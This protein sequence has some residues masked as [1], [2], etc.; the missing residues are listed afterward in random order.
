MYTKNNFKTTIIVIFVGIFSTGLSAFL[1][2]EF[3][4]MFEQMKKMESDFNHMRQ[5]M[6]ERF[7]MVG[8]KINSLAMQWRQEDKNIIIELSNADLIDQNGKQFDIDAQIGYQGSYANM[9]KILFGSTTVSL[10]Y[11]KDNLPNQFSLHATYTSKQK[12]EYDNKH[13]KSMHASTQQGGRVMTF[14]SPLL[15]EKIHIEAD[16]KNKIIRIIIPKK[17]LKQLKQKEIPITFVNE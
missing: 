15:L 17:E 1:P 5:S 6:E 8:N 11:A 9:A 10:N 3:D 12:N 16:I 7:N 13:G 4:D 14:D 2:S